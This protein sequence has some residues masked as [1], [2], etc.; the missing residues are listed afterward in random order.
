RDL[1]ARVAGRERWDDRAVRIVPD[2]RANS[3]GGSERPDDDLGPAVGIETS[4][5]NAEPTGVVGAERQ[6]RE[7]LP[8]ARVE[9]PH[10]AWPAGTGRRDDVRRAV[11]VDVTGRHRRTAG[12]RR[13]ERVE[14]REARPAILSVHPVLRED[15]DLG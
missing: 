13:L 5:R 4:R 8:A 15:A 1:D 3:R 10:F 14:V 2:E 11:A 6:E 7:E 12:E 9:D